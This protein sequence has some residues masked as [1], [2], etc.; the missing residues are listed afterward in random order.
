MADQERTDHAAVGRSLEAAMRLLGQAT[1]PTRS[2][3]PT[4]PVEETPLRGRGTGGDGLVEAVV[5]GYGRLESLE[6]NPTLLRSGTTAIAQYV[7][8]AVT[9]AQDDERRQRQEALG[10]EVDQAALH[11][12]LE[13]VAEQAWR[14]LDGMIGDLDAMVRRLDRDRR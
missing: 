9:A 4:S 8:E 5:G 3:D 2:A 14:G 11:R 6:I 7:V 13:G 1:G 12:Q 10:G